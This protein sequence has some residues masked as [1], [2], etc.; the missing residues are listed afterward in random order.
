MKMSLLKRSLAVFLTAA[1]VTAMGGCGNN[2]SS[3][4][5]QTGSSAVTES[6]TTQ[7]SEATVEAAGDTDLYG[8]EVT[9]RVMV[10]DR[11]DA[12]PGTTTENNT[13]T[14]WIQEQVKELYNINVEYVAVPRSGSDDKLNIMMSGG[15]APDIVFSYGQSLYYSYATS[16]ALRDVS[17][18]YEQYGS[19]IQEYCEEA[20]PISV[21]DGTKYAVMKQRGTEEPRQVAW[22]RQDWLDEL[23]MDM[24][25]TKEELGEYL[26]AVKENNLGGSKTIPWAMSGR[27]DTGKMY[28]SFINSYG[29][30]ANDR[31]AYIYSE[32]Y[33]NV[34]PGVEDGLRQLN[35]WYNDGLITKDFPTDTAE[36]VYTADI[37]NGHVGFVLDD[38]TQKTWPSF[39][40][41]NNNLGHET[42][43]PL[44][45]F[46]TEDGSYRTPYEYR[47]AM[48][49]MIPSTTSDEKAVACMKYLNW[50]A[51]PEV[52]MTIRYTPD[53]IIDE[54]GAAAEP[55]REEKE[56]M[57][58]GGTPDDLCIM[59]LN[60]SWVN[61]VE[62]L[63]KANYT[64]QNTDWA[65]IEWYQNYHEVKAIGKFRYPVYAYI[66]EEEQTY[67]SDMKSRMYEYAYRCI[68]AS[69]GQFDSVY[70][71]EYKELVNAGLNDILDARAE[72]Y[73][74]V[75]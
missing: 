66:S 68:C 19:N 65:T 20:Q 63:A 9:I 14:K 72:Y 32:E 73:D 35:T 69:P 13:L 50:M 5:T 18:L 49:V 12:A 39:E 21:I 44:Q 43:V 70:E 24:P 16:G 31:D 54:S 52:A 8:E 4:N 34:L 26:Y 53:Y 64:S 75:N 27:T 62:V 67:G 41:L 74:S 61:D 25:T 40:I 48:F 3:T 2:T 45:C 57:G 71:T 11:G 37:A 51:D 38:P 36:D 42:F 1:M 56:A 29:T 60:F 47:Y 15:T 10:W 17:D 22:I 46:E 55:T 30:I 59:N 7:G 58:Y 33:I 28:M 6:S 23:G